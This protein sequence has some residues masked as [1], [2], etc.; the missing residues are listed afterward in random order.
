MNR[1]SSRRWAAGFAAIAIGIAVAVSVNPSIAV[2]AGTPAVCAPGGPIEQKSPPVDCPHIT[3]TPSTNLIDLQLVTVSGRDFVPSG[4]AATLQCANGATSQD[5]CDL[6]TVFYVPTSSTGTFV[7]HRVVRRLIT[8]SGGTTVDC[9]STPAACIMA[10]A[11]LNNY[12]EATSVPLSFNPSV[13]PVTPTLFVVPATGLADHQVVKLVGAGMF[14]NSGVEVAQCESGF[15]PSYSTCDFSTESFTPTTAKGTFTI[16]WP[17]HRMLFTETGTIDCASR[18]GACQ[19]FAG[20]YLGS[21]T[22]STTAPLSFNRR[23]PPVA[24]AVA[25]SASSGLRDH[26]LITVTGTGYTPGAN[27]ILIQCE[28]AASTTGPSCDY[29]TEGSAVPGFGGQFLATY[30]VHRILFLG[31]GTFDCA[32]ARHACSIEAVNDRRPSE[33]ASAPMSFNPTVPPVTAAINV[34]PSTGLTD[35]RAVVVSG[36]GFTPYSTVTVNQCGA[37]AGH[38]VNFGYCSFG[39]PFGGGG[40]VSTQV[41]ANGKF[42]VTLFVHTTISDQFGL[43]NCRTKPGACVVLATRF[44]GAGDTAFKPITFK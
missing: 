30:A 39:G 17:V 12:L 1:L 31:I 37:E 25:L 29:S 41:G 33:A 15:P 42:S 8:I 2:G 16:Q 21:T 10:A 7:I 36:T 3:V 27:I 44:S 19:V 24:Q 32:S 43:L 40:G 26:Q 6:S 11:N 35:N 22:Q 14:P 20:Q 34:V 13:P 18:L 5:Q 9:G 23:I 4:E 28:T 38:E